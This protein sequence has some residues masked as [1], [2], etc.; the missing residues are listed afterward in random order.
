M[1]KCLD[2]DLGYMACGP[3]KIH[4]PR[5]GFYLLA[6]VENYSSFPQSHWK[7]TKHQVS[8]RKENEIILSQNDPFGGYY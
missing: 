7:W 2:L 8:Q 6:V 1:S 5:A 3:S 4:R